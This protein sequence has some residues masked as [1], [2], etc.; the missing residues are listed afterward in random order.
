ML[1]PYIFKF[2]ITSLTSIL[3]KASNFE[4]HVEDD[5]FIVLSILLITL[6]L[7]NDKPYCNNKMFDSLK[8]MF[9]ELKRKNPE[10]IQVN[11]GIIFL[12]IR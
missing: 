6:H 2:L 7:K 3:F 12:F 5:F 9:L 4:L 8:K 11:S 1:L 10:I